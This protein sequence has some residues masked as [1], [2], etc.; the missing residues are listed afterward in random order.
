MRARVRECIIYLYWG[1]NVLLPL[2]LSR[3]KRSEVE[4]SRYHES[5][6]LKGFL[7]GTARNDNKGGRRPRPPNIKKKIKI[8]IRGTEK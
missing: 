7:A 4:G 6:T 3:A 8:Y 2:L 5:K 1:N